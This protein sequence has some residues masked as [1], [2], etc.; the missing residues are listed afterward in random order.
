MINCDDNSGDDVFLGYD[1][2]RNKTYGEDMLTL[3]DKEIKQLVDE[4]YNAAKEIILEHKDVLEKSCSLLMEKEK[5]T[6]EEFA[7]LFNRDQTVETGNYSVKE[8]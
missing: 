8:V 5:I 2:A 3:I 4:C 7:A 1:I 6:G